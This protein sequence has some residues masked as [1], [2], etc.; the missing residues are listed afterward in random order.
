[1]VRLLGGVDRLLPLVQEDGD[2]DRSQDTDDDDDDQELDEGEAT[3]VLLLGLANSSEHLLA[4]SLPGIHV[5]SRQ[6]DPLWPSRRR[7]DRGSWAG[8]HARRPP[9]FATPP[10]GGCAL[11]GRVSSMTSELSSPADPDLSSRPDFIR[12]GSPARSSANSTTAGARVRAP[13]GSCL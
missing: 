1:D 5:A 2:R 4:L 11:S 6:A 8:L 3:L 12:S 9:G 13:A 7:T 10:H